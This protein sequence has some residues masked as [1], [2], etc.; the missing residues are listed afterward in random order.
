MQLSGTALVQHAQRPGFNSQNSP[1][2][3]NQ[4]MFNAIK[5]E[6]NETTEQKTQNDQEK[7][8]SMKINQTVV[9]EVVRK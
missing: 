7:A 5:K 8:L 9:K 3:N 2:P 6:E 4:K 1:S